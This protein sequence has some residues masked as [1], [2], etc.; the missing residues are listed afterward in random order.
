MWLIWCRGTPDP[1]R[2]SPRIH[3]DDPDRDR[4]RSE[5]LDVI[6]IKAEHRRLSLS[7]LADMPDYQP[8]GERR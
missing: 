4:D 3:F 5:R 2:L 6:P 8:V 7:K 1:S